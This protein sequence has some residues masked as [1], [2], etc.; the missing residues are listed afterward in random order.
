ML[1]QVAHTV[2]NELETVKYLWQ[3]FKSCW[4][5]YNTVLC[6]GPFKYRTIMY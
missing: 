1:Q 5:A 2:S 3:R 4:A 6:P